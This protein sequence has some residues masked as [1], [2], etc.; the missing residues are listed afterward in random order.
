MVFSCPIPSSH[1]RI[2]NVS[3]AAGYELGREACR[4]IVRA[5]LP[6]Q[7]SATA[8]PDA[9]KINFDGSYLPADD[10]G[11]EIKEKWKEKHHVL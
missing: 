8:T 9:I 2:G 3:L 4:I 6:P 5:A 1:P 11:L 10:T 7:S